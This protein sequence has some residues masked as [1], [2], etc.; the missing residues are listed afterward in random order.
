MGRVTVNTRPHFADATG[1][2]YPPTQS[3][4]RVNVLYLEALT[5][6][7]LC[8]AGRKTVRE[9]LTHHD[10]DPLQQISICG[11]VQAGGGSARG[12]CLTRP[13]THSI[14]TLLSSSPISWQTAA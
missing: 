2:K 9:L 10:S 6:S 13:P 1:A 5:R 3:Y 12:F 4:A 11:A 14:L 8:Y 7:P